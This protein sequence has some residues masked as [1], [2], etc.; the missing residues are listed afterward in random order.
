MTTSFLL[1]F[2]RKSSSFRTTSNSRSGE[3]PPNRLWFF[4][5]QTKSPHPAFECGIAGSW[6]DG[7]QDSAEIS[8]RNWQA[9]VHKVSAKL[10]HSAERS[11]EAVAQASSP[12]SSGGFSPPDVRIGQ[13]RPLSSQPRRLLYAKDL[14]V[15][16]AWNGYSRFVPSGE[17]AV[18]TAA[19]LIFGSARGG[20]KSRR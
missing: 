20:W 9:A 12:A 4:D 2:Y 18:A 1:I 5:M 7:R 6:F 13:G 10:P 16:R 8:H 3:P 19:R 14:G 17:V 15:F 11:E